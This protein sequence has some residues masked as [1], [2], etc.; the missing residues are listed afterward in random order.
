M[1]DPDDGFG[2]EEED[3]FERNLTSVLGHMA[4]VSGGARFGGQKSLLSITKDG[5]VGKKRGPKGMLIS[6]SV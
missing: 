1:A 4:D 3:D 2:V 5:R 6:L